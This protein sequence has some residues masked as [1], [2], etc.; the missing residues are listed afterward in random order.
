MWA[1]CNKV[2]KNQQKTFILIKK[3]C[4]ASTSEAKSK[5]TKGP[6]KIQTGYIDILIIYYKPW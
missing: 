6:G 4:D 1:I 5:Q 2:I 3:I